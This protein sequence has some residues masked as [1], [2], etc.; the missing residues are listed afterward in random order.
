MES[1]VYIQGLPRNISEAEVRRMFERYGPIGSVLLSNFPGYAMV[2]FLYPRDAEQAIELY[3]RNG[4]RLRLCDE[5]PG[6]WPPTDPR[7]SEE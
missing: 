6:P 4:V 2:M 1:R 7:A 5:R 3:G